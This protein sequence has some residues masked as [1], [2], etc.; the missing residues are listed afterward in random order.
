MGLILRMKS[1]DVQPDFRLHW[2]FRVPQLTL[3]SDATDTI[4][5]FKTTK[6]IDLTKIQLILK[7]KF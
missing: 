6:R 2:S 1:E 4:E 3:L 5:G 7:P